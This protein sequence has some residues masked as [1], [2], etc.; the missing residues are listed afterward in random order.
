[1]GFPVPLNQ[2]MRDELKDFIYDTLSSQK[3]KQRDY[4]NPKFDISR[5]TNSEG[6]YNR[7]L[8]GL[9]SLEL[10]QEEFHD[11]E[12]YYSGLLKNQS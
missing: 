1:M 10:W 8:W 3:A 4:M 5:L 6:V 11:K 7:K 12:Q 9:L 2:W